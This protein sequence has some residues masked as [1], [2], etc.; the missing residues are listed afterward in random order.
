MTLT[1]SFI[2]IAYILIALEKWHRT[3]IVFF[4]A[5]LTVVTGLITPD[6]AWA[7]IDYNT[8]GLLLGMMIIVNIMK[9]TGIFRYLA[10]YSV[11]LSRGSVFKLFFTITAIT[12]LA[13]AFLDNVT[14]VMLITPISIFIA[15]MIGIS[16]FPFFIGEIIA[17]NMGGTA[18]LIG[19]PPNVMIGSAAHL[20]F[21]DF[22]TH[23]T[24][25]ALLVYLVF[26]LYFKIFVGP[27]YNL[28]KNFN[29]QSL[30][31]KPEKAIKDYNL[32]KKSLFVFLL[33][34]AGFMLHHVLEL[35]PSIIALTGAAFLLIITKHDPEEV[36]KDV[37][38]ATL[39]F[40]TGFFILVG[41]L[42]KY[43][44]IHLIATLIVS[45]TN[46]VKLLALIV[47]IVSAIISALLDNIPFVAAMIPVI[48]SIN[49]SLG[50]TSNTLWWALAL[51]SCL[52]GNGT[53]VGASA[54]IVVAGISSRSSTPLTFKNYLKY[55]ALATLISILLSGIY[56]ILFL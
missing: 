48:A 3:T 31:I 44:V 24:P 23:L 50:I 4:F 5:T 2:L 39:I 1:I 40:L 34:I 53:L 41:S 22:L 7:A 45:I 30:N 46:N 14:T 56:I 47:L 54:N 28:H 20:S 15:E 11:K 42:E 33:V 26:I 35:E 6:E 49:Q 29:A 52:G 51:G 55:G 27:H 18:T 36:L 25:I 17:S 19:D 8:I 12:W 9:Q 37:E 13:S 10:L 16:P 21:F 38:W 32:L 43:G